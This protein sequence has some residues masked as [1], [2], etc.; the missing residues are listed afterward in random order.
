VTFSPSLSTLKEFTS[1]KTRGSKKIH[2]TKL[3]FGDSMIFSKN[4]GRLELIY[5][6]IL[7]KNIKK[8]KRQKKP[9]NRLFLKRKI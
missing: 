1:F 7:K 2:F 4:E 5:F 3:T 8:I 6:R 9:R